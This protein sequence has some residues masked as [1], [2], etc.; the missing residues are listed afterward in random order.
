LSADGEAYRAT[1]IGGEH[2]AVVSLLVGIPSPD[3]GMLAVLA[4][5]NSVI[6]DC[7]HG[8]PLDSTVRSMILAVKTA[9]GRCIVRIA[10]SAVGQIGALADLGLDG[11]VLAGPENLRDMTT[12]IGLAAFPALGSRSVNPFVPAAGIPGDVA[13]LRVSANSFEL[14]A[15]AETRGFLDEFDELSVSGTGVA[16]WTGIII[17]PYDL[18]ASLGCDPDPGDPVLLDAVL[19]FARAAQLLRIRCGLFAR[20]GDTLRR[21][22]ALGADPDLA[23]VGYDRD[24]WFQ[25]C[26]RRVAS[27]RGSAVSR[28]KFQ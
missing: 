20:D 16:G 17:G 8:F 19:R 7:E 27:V 24:I 1:G 9:G 12:V 2:P 13:R 5:F 14:W 25:E 18:A 28:R 23:V 21:W 26:S 6:L 4:G 11:I 3:L 22:R 10:K 15:M